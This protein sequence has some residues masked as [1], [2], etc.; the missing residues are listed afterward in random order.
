M[1]ENES[2]IDEV[3]EE[4][5][6][7][8]LYKFL[9]KYGWLA[10]L[11]IV[12]IVGASAFWEYN[13]QR[14]VKEARL[15]GD[16]ISNAIN[17]AEGGDFTLL[18]SLTDKQVPG[19]VI[20]M[21]YNAEIALSEQKVAEAVDAYRRIYTNQDV[22]QVLRD[23]AK[24]KTFFLIK[25]DEDS[26]LGLLDELSSPDCAFNL[27]AQEQ[28]ALYFIEINDFKS[29]DGILDLIISNPTA[30]SILVSRSKELKEA[31]GYSGK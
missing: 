26:A 23:L 12:A 27:L 2:F 30:S 8:K 4:L 10:F 29:A 17:S 1:S 13:K 19:A 18:Q 20:A 9:R 14:I 21:F 31:L 11:F 25:E 15:F 28:R 22:K 5:R 3:T 16:S 24:F 6:R 7:D